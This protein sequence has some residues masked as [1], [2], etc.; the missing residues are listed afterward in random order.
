M[1][2]FFLKTLYKARARIEQAVGK[3]KRFKR[4]ALPCEQ[5]DWGGRASVGIP[6]RIP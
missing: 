4:I 1:P 3:L 6:W 5:N 2:A